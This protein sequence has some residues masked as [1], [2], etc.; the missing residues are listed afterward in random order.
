MDTAASR[1]ISVQTGA[2]RTIAEGTKRAVTSGIAK[3]PVPHIDI[4]RD[5]ITDDQI[6]N[7][8]HHGGEGQAVYLYAREDYEFWEDEL[9]ATLEPGNFGENVTIERWPDRTMRVGDRI[10]FDT[11]TG[12]VELELTGPRVPCQ[13]FAARMHELL[14]PDAATGWVKRFTEAR[15]PGFYARVITPGRLGP[16]DHGHWT[17]APSERIGTIELWELYSAEQPDPAAVSRALDS[18]VDGRIRAALANL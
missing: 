11:D 18:P 10:T 1:V 6:E 17:A 15:R 9:D 7:P 5:G 14:G 16:D 2:I 12:Q 4:R 13:K 3:L 8:R